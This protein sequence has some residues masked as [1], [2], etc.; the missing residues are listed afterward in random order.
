MLKITCPSNNIPERKY[1]IF[2]L[3][4][5]LLGCGIK[6]DDLLFDD[7]THDYHIQAGEKEIIVEDHFFNEYPDALS[8]LDISHI[9]DRLEYLHARGK[10]MPIIYGRDRYVEDE[11]RVTIGLDV[12]ASSFFMLTRWEE[13]LLGREA[14]GDCDESL[15]FAVKMGIYQRPVVHE[16]ED[17]F[18]E[19]LSEAGVQLKERKYDVIL[20]HDVDGFVTPSL[21]RIAKDFVTQ[22]LHGSPKNTILHLTWKEEIKYK[23]AF[24]SVFDQFAL[25]TRLSRKS[26][27][28]EWFYFKVCARGETEST[29]IFDSAQTKDI[30][31]RLK[32][33]TSPRIVMGFHPSQSTFGNESQWR[34]EA[35]RIESLLGSVPVIGRNHH[36]LYSFD[37]LRNWENLAKRTKR[38]RTHISNCVFH[39]KI[40]FRSGVGVGYTLFDIFQRRPMLLMERP[41][42]IMD[43]VIRYHMKDN[44]PEQ[45]WDEIKTVVDYSKKYRCELVLTWHIYIRNQK[46]IRDYY[47]WCERVICYAKGQ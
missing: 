41:C 13:S 36:L 10:V 44:S 29:Y 8:Y 6:E 23:M 31:S 43:T 19:L 46:I 32:R 21:S 27:I 25:Y 7:L 45:I 38:G 24:P 9:P 18:G 16:Y 34:I 35:T 5:E 11:H 17:L 4:N 42:Q 14:K 33:L 37:T 2:V 30:V 12:F 1:I 39:N 26:D 15:L 20:S 28:Q 3:F 22:S 47:D 40:G